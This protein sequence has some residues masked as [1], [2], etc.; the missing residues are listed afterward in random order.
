MPDQST[1][2]RLGQDIRT[3][4]RTQIPRTPS[5]LLEPARFCR[6]MPWKP[7]K[8][9]G[10]CDEQETEIVYEAGRL[11]P[12]ELQPEAWARL[13]NP[14]C[15]AGPSPPQ[16]FKWRRVRMHSPKL[17]QISFWPCKWAHTNHTT[18][19]ISRTP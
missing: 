2:T 7:R 10:D 5:V 1:E 3:L 12:K 6:M 17:L 13:R 4:S 8:G 14:K 19:L 9:K 15:L 18:D 11:K 16:T